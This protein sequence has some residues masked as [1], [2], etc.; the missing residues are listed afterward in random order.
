MIWVEFNP[1]NQGVADD[2]RVCGALAERLSAR[3]NI[4]HEP[5]ISLA[6]N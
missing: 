6:D 3:Q 1:R 4:G 5:S 2:T